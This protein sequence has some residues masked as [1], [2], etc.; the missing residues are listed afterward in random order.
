MKSPLRGNNDGQVRVFVYGTL[1]RGQPNAS[2]FKYCKAE[3]LG[4][5]TITGA[6]DML[7]LGSFPA[8]IPDLEENL[9][10]KIYGEIWAGDDEMLA[11]LDQLEGHP[12]F[13]KR[14]KVW[15]DEMKKRVWVYFLEE[16]WTGEADD[17]LVSGCW[18]ASSRE[19]DKWG[20]QIAS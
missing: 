9:S 13:Y 8:L 19:I 2:I 17:V 15:S 10:T 4:L 11:V 3:C 16:E 7:D 1:K 20:E 6:F 5:D 12:T 18:K 14:K